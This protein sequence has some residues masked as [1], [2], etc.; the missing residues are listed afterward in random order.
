MQ[1]ITETLSTNELASWNAPRS[2]ADLRSFVSRREDEI[3][4]EDFDF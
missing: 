3:D 4:V 2:I 1:T